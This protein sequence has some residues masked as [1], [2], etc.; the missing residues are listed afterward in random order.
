MTAPRVNLRA[1][2]GRGPQRAPRPRPAFGERLR[3]RAGLVLVAAADRAEPDRWG[4]GVALRFRAASVSGAWLVVPDDLGRRDPGRLDAL[5]GWAAA[6]QITTPGGPIPLAICTR[7]ELCDPSV[8]PLTTTIYTGRGWFVTAD[9]GATLGLLAEHARS[10]TDRFWRGG[11]VLGIPGWGLVATWTSGGREHQGWQPL[12]HRP[13]LRVKPI[14]AHFLTAR[15][16]PAGRRGFDTHGGRV[17]AWEHGRPFEGRVV[18]LIGPAHALDGHDHSD[19]GVHLESFGLPA[20]DLATAVPVDKAGGEELLDGAR[21]IHRLALALDDEAAQ[22]CTTSLEREQGRTRIGLQECYSP[23]SLATT[24][25][26]R[27]KITPPLRKFAVPGDRALDRWTAACHGGIVTADICCELLPVLDA[28]IRSAYPAAWSVLGCWPTLCAGALHEVDVTAELR[29]LCERVVAG[30]VAPLFDPAT[31]RGLGL[32][33]VEVRPDGEPWPLDIRHAHGSTL[34]VQP[35][36]STMRIP[37]TWPDVLAAALASGRVPHIVAATRLEPVPG[38]VPERPRGVVLRDGVRARAGTDP[39][40]ALVSLRVA[41]KGRGDERVAAMLRVVVNAAAWGGFARLDQRRDRDGRLTETPA[42]WTWPPV[43]ACVPAVVRLWLAVV[44]HLVTTA[45]GSVIARDTD[46]V[47][48]LSSPDASDV[49]LSDGRVLQALPWATV[50]AILGRFDGLD[51]FGTGTPVWTTDRGEPV[52]PLHIVSLAP[53]RYVLAQA[54]RDGSGWEVVAGTEH[55]LAGAEIDP[56]GWTGRDA[57]GRHRWWRPVAQ[58]AVDV[59]AARR[60]GTPAPTFAAPWDIPGADPFPKLARLGDD[61]A[62][63]FGTVVRA[64]VVAGFGAPLYALDDGGDLGNWAG[65]GWGDEHGSAAVTTDPRRVGRRVWLR[66]LAD[67]ANAWCWPRPAED[68]GMITID[69]RLVR[70]TG[71]GGALLD[72]Q[73]GD[74]DARPEDYEIVY[75]P[76]EL[77]AWAREEVGRVGVVAFA[78]HYGISRR[79]ADRIRLG[80]SPSA[81]TLA[82]IGAGVDRGRRPAVPVAGAPPRTCAYPDCEQP[83]RDRSAT[84]GDRHRVAL[85]RL[86]VVEA[87]SAVH[88]DDKCR[89]CGAVLLGAARK[90]PCPVCGHM[91]QEKELA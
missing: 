20:V 77:A 21:A 79:T 46:G 83:A 12:L 2:P 7:T 10:P 8:G 24:V 58:H 50:D 51:P 11:W 41:A 52:R 48:I 19:L 65:L 22:W 71:R 25:L 73:L 32:T 60:D 27:T 44:D 56:P 45:G 17:G 29:R 63:P 38:S 23:A 82:K 15:F 55:A 54:R 70:R 43:A 84:C 87:A 88:S 78:E 86:T 67:Y 34:H 30:D 26:R 75:R 5:T 6:Q 57:G 13:V 69:P 76:D 14:G 3:D 47:A 42:E 35:A 66:S 64:E 39:V 1:W 72:A 89:G 4:L 85:R 68:L 90:G 33:L 61:S 62:R 9:E 81:R 74:P 49:P 28:D 40:V 91:A 80:Y 31:Y 18:D 59:A 36:R 37:F 16:A 53:K